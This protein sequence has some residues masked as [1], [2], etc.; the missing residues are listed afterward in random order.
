VGATPWNEITGVQT[1]Y[2]KGIPSNISVDAVILFGIVMPIVGGIAFTD[3]TTTY[4][5]MSLAAATP[6]T[7]M[8]APL[9]PWT[10]ISL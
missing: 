5:E 7:E 8:S 3:P 2:V 1:P 9:T 6:S 10:K 4:T